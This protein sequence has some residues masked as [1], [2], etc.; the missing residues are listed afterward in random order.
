MGKPAC[1]HCRHTFYNSTICCL[2][3]LS[4]IAMA[5]TTNNEQSNRDKQHPAVVSGSIYGAINAS[6]SELWMIRLPNRLAGAWE[7]APEGTD[8]GTL[9]FTKSV[10]N[11][12]ELGSRPAK[13][14]K[15]N[16][17]ESSSKLSIIIGMCH[18]YFRC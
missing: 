3:P 13:R 14:T 10:G 8:L 9:V 1:T 4:A 6:S 15:L 11:N 7:D 5:P 18:A 17:P 12:N 2:L 16:A